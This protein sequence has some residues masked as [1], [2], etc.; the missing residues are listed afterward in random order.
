VGLAVLTTGSAFVS[1]PSCE[2][3]LTTVNPCGTIFSFCEP[4]EIDA[5]FADTPD[6]SLDP[7]CS[8]PFYGVTNPTSAGDCSTSVV[9]PTTPGSRP[10]GGQP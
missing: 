9:F 1:I 2:G 7:T 10:Q 6:F 4:Y 5:L 8:I 3:L